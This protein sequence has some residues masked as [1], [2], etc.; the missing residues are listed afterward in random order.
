[1][2]IYQHITTLIESAA[3]AATKSHSADEAMKYAQAALNA[4]NAARILWDFGSMKKI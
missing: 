1:M 4:A 2:D 3:D